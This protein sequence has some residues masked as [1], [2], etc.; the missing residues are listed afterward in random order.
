MMMTTDQDNTAC[1]LPDKRC[2]FVDS[3]QR[4]ILHNICFIVIQ[5]KYIIQCLCTSPSCLLTVILI[6]MTLGSPIA[7]LLFFLTVLTAMYLKPTRSCISRQGHLLPP[8]MAQHHDIILT[9]NRFHWNNIMLTTSLATIS[10]GHATALAHTSTRAPQSKCRRRPCTN[11]A[12]RRRK[13]QRILQSLLQ[14][15]IQLDANRRMH[16]IITA[17]SP[18]IKRRSRLLGGTLLSSLL[19]SDAPQQ[20]SK[21][22]PTQVSMPCSPSLTSACMLASTPTNCTNR[23]SGLR[24]VITPNTCCITRSR[25]ALLEPTSPPT[26]PPTV[27]P[28]SPP[29]G[30]PTTVPTSPHPGTPTIVHSVPHAPRAQVTASHLRPHTK[31]HGIP[32]S[33]TDDITP[34]TSDEDWFPLYLLQAS[35][36]DKPTATSTHPRKLLSKSEFADMTTFAWMREMQAMGINMQS[37]SQA[38]SQLLPEAQRC[39]SLYNDYDLPNLDIASLSLEEALCHIRILACRL[40]RSLSE[41]SP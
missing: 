30:P 25:V 18:A 29:S 28:T 35:K 11:T 3:I 36:L 19:D 39:C 22:S 32:L 16:I 31:R 6:N 13:R 26:G 12:R 24:A 21:S 4:G 37:P 20:Q 2:I 38:I 5:A 14:H 27:V 8:T 17:N 9:S 41:G 40:L 7:L 34:L 15:I 10:L 23:A 1:K 33:T